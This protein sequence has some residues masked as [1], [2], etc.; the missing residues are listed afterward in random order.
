MKT[1]DRY[2]VRQYL[3]NFLVL[4]AVF[5]LLFVVVDVIFNLDEV[6][7]AGVIETAAG[8][9]SFS[10]MKMLGAVLG[11][12]GPLI[13][14]LY[15]F[16]SGL[17]VVAAMG[18]TFAGLYRTGEL[19]GFMTSGIS[20][21]RVA[22]SVLVAGFVLTA[23]TLPDQ[24][25]LIPRFRDKLTRAAKDI[26]EDSA[27]AFAIKYAV[28]DRGSLLS[29]GSF[30]RA[31][32]ELRDV[33]ILIRNDR[34]LTQERVTAKRAAWDGS[35]GWQLEG[36]SSIR[37][38]TGE[39]RTGEAL[40]IYEEGSR[41]FPT[42]LSPEVLIARH[43]SFYPRLLALPDLMRLA[44]NPNVDTGSIRQIMHSRFS[45]LVLNMLVLV[46]GLPFFLLR[47][48]SNM[49]L[50]GAKAAALCL[51]AW[52]AG[53]VLMQVGAGNLSPVVSAWLPVVIGLPVAAFMLGMVKT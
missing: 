37:P 24:E 11:F 5:V 12:Y 39:L 42:T 2:I 50:Q 30:D 27:Q 40:T 17:L 38:E 4:F 51:S 45:L 8:E 3:I 22:A 15:V 29:A 18:F 49:I 19:I 9:E 13:A 53:L 44:S 48:P 1:L 31:K 35:R 6:L 52:G 43:E 7:E 25:L 36:G 34:G 21:Y 10:F 33:T 28:D 14:L 41:F 32:N 16:F 47:E 46:M 20:M 26:K 23:L